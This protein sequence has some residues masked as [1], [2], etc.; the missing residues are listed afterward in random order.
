MQALANAFNLMTDQVRETLAGLLVEIGDR[1]RAESAARE[2]EERVRAF[3]ENA[4]DAEA[5]RITLEIQA[6][7]RSLV[8]VTDDGT[9]MNRDDAL[10]TRTPE[11]FSDSQKTQ[12][13][14]P[15]ARNGKP[16]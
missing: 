11:S 16:L 1:T 13:A 5:A 9:G 6:G 4:L 12:D 10:L 15:S 8:R 14:K 2:S 3:V 7:G